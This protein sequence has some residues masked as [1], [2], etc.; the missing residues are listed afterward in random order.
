MRIGV[1]GL[2]EDMKGHVVTLVL[3]KNQMKACEVTDY[4]QLI[5]PVLFTATVS[6]PTGKTFNVSHPLQFTCGVIDAIRTDPQFLKKV[7][8]LKFQELDTLVIE[9][10]GPWQCSASPKVCTKEAVSC[11]FG[12]ISTDF[13]NPFAS[14]I[15]ADVAVLWCKSKECY[16]RATQ[17]LRK[18]TRRKFRGRTGPRTNMRV[19]SNNECSMIEPPDTKFFRCTV[20]KI[21]FYCS[22]ECQVTDWRKHGHKR[23][24]ALAVK[25]KPT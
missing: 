12:A 3:T 11:T 21:A 22:Q 14:R 24:C 23:I 1:H 4:Q 16:T 25:K 6:D 20:C 13:K 17:N 9:N 18:L 2:E 8:D 5:V 19:C 7:I 10:N 15:Y